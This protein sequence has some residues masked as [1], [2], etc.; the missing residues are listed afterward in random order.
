MSEREGVA[1][2]R[3]QGEKEGK[4]KKVAVVLGQQFRASRNWTDFSFLS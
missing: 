4:E 3:E 1:K 2:E